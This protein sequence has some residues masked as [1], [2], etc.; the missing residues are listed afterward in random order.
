MQVWCGT[1]AYRN[2]IVDL[3]SYAGQTVRFRFRV[4]TDGSQGLTPHGW[5]VDD[6]KV[7]SCRTVPTDLLFTD[8]FELEG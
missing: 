6:I 1:R 8:G 2:S 7:Q 4:S 5:Y 3:D